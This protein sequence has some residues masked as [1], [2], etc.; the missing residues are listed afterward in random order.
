MTMRTDPLAPQGERYTVW[1]N[2]LDT[3]QRVDVFYGTGGHYNERRPTRYTFPPKK[4]VEVPSRFDSAI[5]RVQCTEEEC[6]NRAPG[7]CTHPNHVGIVIG[8]LAP[9]LQRKGSNY[10]L[11]E[12]LDPNHAKLKEMEAQLAAADIA[13]RAAE[14]AQ[15]LAEAK[16]QELEAELEK[17]TR[18]EAKVDA[19][20]AK[21]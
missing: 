5:H 9:C 17:Q 8:G 7:F 1:F 20:A 6:R 11:L 16:R 13:R 15:I 10:K 12:A 2:P 19:K 14:Q 18:P 3:E 4:E 21:K